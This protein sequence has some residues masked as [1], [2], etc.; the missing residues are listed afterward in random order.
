[1][2]GTVVLVNNRSVLEECGVYPPSEFPDLVRLWLFFGSCALS[3][4]CAYTAIA[5]A[6]P[7]VLIM[8]YIH[9]A[10]DE[11]VARES[12]ERKLPDSV[13]LEPRLNDLVT[14]GLASVKDG[15]YRLTSKGTRLARFIS[16]FFVVL[17]RRTE[18]GG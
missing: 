14:D 7:T 4:V 15:I 17:M 10:G 13:L 8:L 9:R 16:Y 11:G 3:Y 12:I 6:S 1:M 2:I 18:K 5:A